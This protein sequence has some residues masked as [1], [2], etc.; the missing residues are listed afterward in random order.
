M[1]WFTSTKAMAPPCPTRPNA[2]RKFGNE[3]PG[4]T[5]ANSPAFQR[6][7]V[8]HTIISP[9][10]TA[11]R[12]RDPV[13]VKPSLR[14]SNSS[15]VLPGVETPG[16]SRVVPPGQWFAIRPG[17]LRKAFPLDPGRRAAAGCS[18]HGRTVHQRRWS[19]TLRA[20]ANGANTH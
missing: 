3:C 20:N 5:N 1:E 11:E 10:G 14:D 16:Y 4:G 8:G 13:H 17:N 18:A 15:D 2:F 12:W 6:W 9:E 19:A 7:E